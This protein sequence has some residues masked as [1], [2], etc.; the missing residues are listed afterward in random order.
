MTTD[1]LLRWDRTHLWHPY[2]ST[3]DPLSV[4]PVAG[5]EGVRIRLEDGR[6]L[7]DGMSSWWSTIHGYNHPVLNEALRYQ[8]LQMSHIMFGGFTHRSAVELGRLLVEEVL[9]SGLDRL[10]YADSGSVAVEVSLK[11]ALQYQIARGEKQRTKFATIRSG[12]HGD[13]WHAMSVCDPVTGMHGLFGSALPVQYFVPQPSVPFDA[14]WDDTA[15]D[16]MRALLTAHG[17]EIAAV[18]VEPVVQGAG[19]MY[20]YHPRY[21]EG[22]RSLTDKYGTL[23]IFDEIATGFGRTGQLLATYHTTIHPD[24]ICLGKALT[25][26]Y[27]TL[28]VTAT[29]QA[30]ADTI[31]GG[32]AG[33]FMHGPTF[34]ANPLACAVGAASLRLL[35][36][37][38]WQERVQQIE[39][40]MRTGLSPLATHPSVLE[41]RC[42]GA[43]GVV[44]MNE[45]VDMAR[46]IPMFVQEGIWIRPFGRLVYVM[47]PFGVIGDEDLDRL[48]S[49]MVK[50][51][52]NYPIDGR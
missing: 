39:Q 26:G 48:I 25:G 42:L 46:L 35:L 16:P 6:E 50:V 28:S 9:P 14:D 51:I 41:V 44:E 49:G 31:C 47:P 29:T 13:T 17:N 15:L 4:Y 32:E 27:M 30:I 1:E 23:L 24:I 8:S 20:F 36:S 2:T 10:F 12:Y 18:I 40:H 11:M 34:M 37:S 3:I 7:I 33:C 19:G 38:P 5:A 43:I 45:P 52:H 21:L 22:L